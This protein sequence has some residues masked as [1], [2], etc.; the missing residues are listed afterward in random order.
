MALDKAIRAGKEWRKAYRKSKAFD[1][2]CRNHGGCERCADNRR[3]RT[4]RELAR[5]DPRLAKED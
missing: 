2:S 3:V 4:L 1:S 5:T